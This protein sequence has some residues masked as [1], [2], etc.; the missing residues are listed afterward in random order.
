MFWVKCFDRF[1]GTQVMWEPTHVHSIVFR[2]AAGKSDKY[3]GG[4]GAWTIV[5]SHMTQ[6]RGNWGSRL[7][8]MGSTPQELQA[9]LNA[10]Q[11]FNSPAG[12]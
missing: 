3:L 4:W 7:S 8:E 6:A 1:N 2:D 9:V 10:L 5:N 11:S 12:L